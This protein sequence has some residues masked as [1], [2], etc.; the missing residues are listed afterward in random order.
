M[1]AGLV[2]VLLLREQLGCPLLYVVEDLHLLLVREAVHFVYEHLEL[3]R[4]IDVVAVM[5]R[6]DQTRDGLLILVLVLVFLATRSDRSSFF[7]RSSTAYL[8]VYDEYERAAALEQSAAVARRIGEKVY[9]TGAVVDLKG[10]E[11][12]ARYV[13]QMS[14]GS[15]V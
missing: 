10:D 5:H 11:R 1:Y 3:D 15:R 4:R 14:L 6:R 9:L 8:S 13:L 2:A 7:Y 12:T